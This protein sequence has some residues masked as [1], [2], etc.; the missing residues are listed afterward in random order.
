MVFK[1]PAPRRWAGEIG[2]GPSSPQGF[3]GCSYA[4]SGELRGK[5]PGNAENSILFVEPNHFPQHL[6]DV[7]S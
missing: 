5:S 1:P 7:C 6:G 3:L 2:R 4:G